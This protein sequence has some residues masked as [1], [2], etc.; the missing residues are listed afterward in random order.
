MDLGNG[1]PFTFAN[2]AISWGQPNYNIDHDNL[3]NNID[4]EMDQEHNIRSLEVLLVERSEQDE[5]FIQR[6]ETLH[7]KHIL[8]D[9]YNVLKSKLDAL[10]LDEV[11]YTSLDQTE[12]EK[13]TVECNSITQKLDENLINFK[14]KTV[15]LWNE[16]QETKELYTEAWNKLKAYNDCSLETIKSLSVLESVEEDQDTKKID[17]WFKNSHDKLKNHWNIESLKKRYETAALKIDL[18]RE[19]IKDV[20]ELS[21]RPVCP[22]CWN[23]GVQTFNMPCG[24]TQCKKCCKG[25]DVKDLHSCPV[26]RQTVTEVKNLYF[27]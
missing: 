19:S 4:G 5:S 21:S 3:G 14:N 9:L 8:N 25:T 27:S 2:N 6:Q 12:K 26:C 7:S 18:L 16:L 11:T 17:E 15:L 20:S 13:I 1:T 10:E 24:H 22:I 23:D